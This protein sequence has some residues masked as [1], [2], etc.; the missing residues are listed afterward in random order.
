MSSLRVSSLRGETN[1][2]SP[3]FP[4]GVVVSGVVTSTTFSGNLTGNVTGNISGT[5]GSFRGDV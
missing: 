3:T 4:D 5:T 1:G 2:S